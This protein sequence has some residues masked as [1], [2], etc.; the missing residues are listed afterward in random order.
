[1]GL[2]TVISV[3]ITRFAASSSTITVVFAAFAAFIVLAIVLNVLNQLLF[4]NP[5]EPPVVFHWVPVIGSTISYGMEP[6]KFFFECR[7]KVGRDLR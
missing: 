7:E 1:M 2:L 5:H 3:P 6:Y 4:Q